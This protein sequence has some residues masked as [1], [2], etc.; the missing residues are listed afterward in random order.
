MSTL[1]VTALPTLPVAALVPGLGPAHPPPFP[2]DRLGGGGARL[3]YFARNGIYHGLRA[4]GV[5]RGDAVAMPAYHH[6][7]E[8]EAVRATGAAVVFYRVDRHMRADLDD[9]ERA[10]RDP[11][12]RALYLTHYAGFAQPAADARAL[13]RARGLHLVEDCALSLLAR[14]PDGA[15]LGADADLAVFCLYK[16]LPVPHGGVAVAR[17]PLPELPPPPLGATLHHLGG[18]LLARGEVRGGRAGRWLRQWARRFSRSVVDK[19]VEN[20]Q[21]G[22]QHLDRDELALGASPL[23][24]RLL[25]RLDATMVATR[26]RRNYARLLARLGDAAPVPTGEL[27]PGAVPLFLPLA[28]GDRGRALAALAARGVE[29]IDFWSIGDP[30]CDLARFPDVRWLRRHVIEVPLHQ[31]LDDEAIDRIGEVVTEVLHA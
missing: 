21:T 8:V 23:L 16:A 7:V 29:A 9:A 11:R 1:A 28:V 15:P 25:R 5:G 18:S 27:P 26:R 17:A 6:G 13:A 3:Y 19:V 2:L 24:L 22:T 31:D 14:A 12:V 4:L 20:V 30:A 10:A